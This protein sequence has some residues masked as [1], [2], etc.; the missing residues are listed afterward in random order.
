MDGNMA[1]RQP[2]MFLEDGRDSRQMYPPHYPPRME[3]GTVPCWTFPP[4]RPR[5]R[6]WADGCSAGSVP[7]TILVMVLALVFAALGLGAYEIQNL[8]SRLANLTKN[9]D[10]T[11][12]QGHFT[13]P[14]RQIGFQGDT[15]PTC[16]NRQAAHVTINTHTVAIHKT[17]QWEPDYGRAFTKGVQYHEGGLQ[18]NRTGL[19]FIYS[20]VEILGN[21]C[22]HPRASFLHTVFMRR[23]KFLPKTLMEGHKEDY[24]KQARHEVWT[25]N[26][27]LGAVLELQ[28]HDRVYVNASH[29]DFI[30]PASPFGN[31]FGLYQIA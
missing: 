11:A 19:Y 22:L 15:V 10:D 23:K 16:V 7:V 4:A 5:K 20:R 12:S 30:N 18:V 6:S 13:A 26:S 14:Q 8:Q 1:G 25:S 2:Q 21:K 27:Y 24:C 29:P 31:Y 3:P 17:L 28:Q 9:M